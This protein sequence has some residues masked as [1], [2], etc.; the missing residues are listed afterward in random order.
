MVYFLQT[1]Q[2]I[3]DPEVFLHNLGCEDSR[4]RLLV[5]PVIQ[6]KDLPTMVS[7]RAFQQF[8]IKSAQELRI[9]VL[10]V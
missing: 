7:R 4:K 3:E 5:Y 6:G 1:P 2:K 10:S 9:V 8:N